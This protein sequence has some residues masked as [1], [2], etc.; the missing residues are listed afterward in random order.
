MKKI[1]EIAEE[2]GVSR[3]AIYKR[4][5]STLKQPLTPFVYKD[6]HGVTLI[7]SRGVEIIRN[8]LLSTNCQQNSQQFTGVDNSRMI[9]ILNEQLKAKDK[10]ISELNRQLET[11]DQQLIAKDKQFEIVSI[12]FQNEQKKGNL[13]IEQQ[14]PKGIKKWFGKSKGE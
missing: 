2:L 14:K 11:K 6:E 7:K 4:V 10:Q 3:Q 5:N 9:E 8:S 1:S 13:L 12:L